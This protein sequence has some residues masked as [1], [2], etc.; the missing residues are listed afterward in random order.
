MEVNRLESERDVGRAWNV[1]QLN[2]ATWLHCASRY[3]RCAIWIWEAPEEKAGRAMDGGFC[4]AT[5]LAMQLVLMKHTHRA[6]KGFSIIM[7]NI[8]DLLARGWCR[9][10]Q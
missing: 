2:A 9:G 5:A 6:Y 10:P 4:L 1:C 8:N 3:S 7:L